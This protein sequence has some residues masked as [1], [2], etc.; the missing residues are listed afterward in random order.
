MTMQD[1][2]A[3]VERLVARAEELLVQLPA[4]QRTEVD[5]AI[6]VYLTMRD[7]I[8]NREATPVVLRVRAD[9]PPLSLSP[10]TAP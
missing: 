6:A 8:R 1:E 4:D 3:Q 2:N 10:R 9:G 7:E 5:N